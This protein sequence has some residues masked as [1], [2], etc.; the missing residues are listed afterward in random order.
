VILIV[1]AVNFYSRSY[2]AV[3]T[4][5]SRAVLAQTNTKIF[6]YF[7][8]L[9]VALIL[10]RR[11]LRYRRYDDAEGPRDALFQLKSCQLLHNCTS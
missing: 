7:S 5:S 8:T 4:L 11:R 1:N 9:I 6:Q 2:S 3:F 10:T